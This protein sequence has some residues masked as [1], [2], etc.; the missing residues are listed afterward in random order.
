MSDEQLKDKRTTGL[1]NKF[2]VTRTDGK[3]EPGEKH[4]GCDYF[5][6]DL[7]HDPHAIPALVAYAA[8]CE[9]DYPLLAR[10]LILKVGSHGTPPVSEAG[11]SAQSEAQK[12]VTSNPVITSD[13]RG[14]QQGKG[15]NRG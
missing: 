12:D 3:S 8:S 13:A 6:L 7:T 4:D 9:T 11:R 2:T 1:Y 15:V 14:R 5:V 10:D